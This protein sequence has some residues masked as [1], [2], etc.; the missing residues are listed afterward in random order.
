MLLS[1]FFG[2]LRLDF[3]KEASSI[4]PGLTFT[5][6]CLGH[7]VRLLF[8]EAFGEFTH[9]FRYFFKLVGCFPHFIPRKALLNNIRL[10]DNQNF[11]SQ[12]S[13][14]GRL[15]RVVSGMTSNEFSLP[16]VSSLLNSSL[17]ITTLSRSSSSITC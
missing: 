3:F 14:F 4:W 11:A 15:S 5:F 17:F 16:Q 7:F 12:L 1:P 13:R 8:V 10:L 9:L 6:E 2:C